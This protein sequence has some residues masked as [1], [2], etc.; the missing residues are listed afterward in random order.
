[1]HVCEC[2]CV[3]L[4]VCAQVVRAPAHLYAC[5]H[6]H[7]W[8]SE[9]GGQRVMP[10][11]FVYCS[12]FLRQDF[13]QN[14]KFLGLARLPSQLVPGTCLFLFPL[15]WD[16][17]YLTFYMVAG[18]KTGPHACPTHSFWTESFLE[19]LP[20]WISSSKINGGCC[21]KQVELSIWGERV[22]MIETGWLTS[23]P[24]AHITQRCLTRLLG[25]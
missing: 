4:C 11:V 10:H 21:C 8:L 16:C 24:R 13:P 17:R 2:A 9:C 20:Y 6:M 19:Q 14:L 1:M 22:N 12:Y 15:C 18:N 25:T 23:R 7:T 3:S 5:A